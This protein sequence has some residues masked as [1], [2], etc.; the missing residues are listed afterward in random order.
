MH[1]EFYCKVPDWLG[2][3]AFASAGPP[4]QAHH[5]RAKEEQQPA[6]PYYISARFGVVWRA[7][8][9]ARHTTSGR[10]FQCLALLRNCGQGGAR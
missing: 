3:L 8:L 4:T 6:L 2:Q 7:A 5:N 1:L 9:K 10:L